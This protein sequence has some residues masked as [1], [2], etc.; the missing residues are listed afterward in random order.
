[1][2]LWTVH[3]RYLDAQGLVALWREALLAQKVLQGGTKGYKNHPQLVRFREAS[4]PKAAIATYLVAVQEEAANRGYAFDASTIA[5]ARVFIT[6]DETEGQLLYEWRHLQQKLKRRDAK[7]HKTHRAV[8]LPAP[9]PLFSDRSRRR[10]PVGTCRNGEIAD[11][12][13]GSLQPARDTLAFT[14]S[15]GFNGICR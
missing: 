14:L 6:S 12:Q 1:M 5:A 3:P 13:S 11:E 15:R 8:A 7:R 10:A 9:H 4:D 2:R